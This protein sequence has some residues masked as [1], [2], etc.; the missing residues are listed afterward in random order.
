ME[1]LKIIELIKLSLIF[2]FLH[3]IFKVIIKYIDNF[4][5]DDILIVYQ[6]INLIIKKLYEIIALMFL[7]N[8][9]NNYK[10]DG[11]ISEFINEF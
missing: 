7:L 4:N 8:E 3:I 2:F 10:K 11:K 9:K 1:V 6:N 5:E